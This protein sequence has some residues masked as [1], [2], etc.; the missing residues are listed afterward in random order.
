M[1]R[2]VVAPYEGLVEVGIGL[3]IAMG[4]EPREELLECKHQEGKQE[5]E[6]YGRQKSPLRT[7]REENES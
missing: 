2:C 7:R 4:E 1:S 6:A 3:S 5:K